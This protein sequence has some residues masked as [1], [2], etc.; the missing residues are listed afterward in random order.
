MYK[1]TMNKKEI[2]FLGNSSFLQRRVLPAVKKFTNLKI[3]ICSK[4]SKINTDLFITENNY[5]EAIKKKPYLVY[6]SLVNNLHFKYTLLSLQN[7][8]HVI[9]DKPITNNFVKTKYLVSL[10]KKKN[11][12]LA[13][14]TLFDNHRIFN[15]INKLIT[16][17]NKLIHIQSNFN[18]P[19]YKNIKILKKIEGDC[20][21]DMSPYAAAMIRI[22]LRKKVQKICIKKK[23]FTKT[24]LVK[25]FNILCNNSNISYFGNFGVGSEYINQIIFYTQNKIIYLDDRA[26][27]IPP[28]MNIQ[29]KIKYKNKFYFYKIKKDDCIFNYIKDIFI[30]LKSK[31]LKIYYEK[32]LFDAKM[33]EYFKK[34]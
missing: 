2:L 8:C 11:L 30:N 13:E 4:S 32:I 17:K 9:V 7:N 22:Y 18:I 29:L 31:K 14:A 21:A 26:F 25:N 16:N 27:A 33:R 10:A 23:C 34:S 3:S 6:I 1:Q 15:Y 24:H 19:R 5:I 28:D 20:L 12:L